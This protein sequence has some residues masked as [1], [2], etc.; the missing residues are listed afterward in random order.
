MNLEPE[1]ETNTTKESLLPDINSPNCGNEIKLED[2]QDYPLA[3]ANK[4]I[5]TNVRITLNN[6]L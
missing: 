2:H 3:K 5:N 6:S 4:N 1:F